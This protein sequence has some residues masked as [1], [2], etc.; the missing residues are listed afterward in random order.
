LYLIN[1]IKYLKGNKLIKEKAKPLMGHQMQ[2]IKEGGR[3]ALA[4]GA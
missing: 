2:A 4:P 1:V 3:P